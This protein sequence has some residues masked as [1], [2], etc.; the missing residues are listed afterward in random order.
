MVLLCAILARRFRSAVRYWLSGI[1]CPVLAVGCRPARVAAAE[2]YYLRVPMCTW[3][4][5]DIR[6]FRGVAGRRVGGRNW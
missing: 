1:G 4:E 6:P 5:T 2:C 3:K